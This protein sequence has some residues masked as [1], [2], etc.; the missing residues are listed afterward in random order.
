M[1]FGSICFFEEA[2]GEHSNFRLI[3]RV[4]FWRILSILRNGRGNKKKG[5]GQRKN[6]TTMDVPRVW[7]FGE[8]STLINLL[9]VISKGAYREDSQY[10]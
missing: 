3:R 5:E 7:H 2:S 6:E 10:S 9:R 1:A 4:R 8:F